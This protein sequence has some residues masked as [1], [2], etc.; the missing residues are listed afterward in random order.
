MSIEPATGII[1]ILA[2]PTLAVAQLAELPSTVDPQLIVGAFVLANSGL[3]LSVIF[4]QVPVTWVE[5]SNLNEKEALKATL[6]GLIL[7]FA[8]TWALA[9][10]LTPFLVN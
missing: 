10:F 8:T 9:V 3:P 2:A 4:G 6:I 7:R 1:S 5:T